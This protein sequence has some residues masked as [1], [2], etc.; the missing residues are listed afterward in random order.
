[1]LYAAKFNT[2]PLLRENMQNFVALFVLI[3][4]FYYYHTRFAR[5][6]RVFYC[7][8]HRKGI[9]RKNDIFSDKICG[10]KQAWYT[11]RR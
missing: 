9:K 4:V 5:K 1:M 10:K 11:G 3:N 6:N 8:E 7:I 2:L